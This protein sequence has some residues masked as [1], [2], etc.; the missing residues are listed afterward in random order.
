MTS[1]RDEGA[2][3]RRRAAEEDEQRAHPLDVPAPDRRFAT[4]PTRHRQSSV[5]IDVDTTI[6]MP[7]AANAREA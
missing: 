2:R 6:A 5:E 1:A 7:S 3:V 4:R